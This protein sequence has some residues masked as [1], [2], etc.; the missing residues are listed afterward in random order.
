M[1]HVA[2]YC[3]FLLCTLYNIP[4]PNLLQNIDFG[5][6]INLSYIHVQF[7]HVHCTCTCT[8]KFVILSA[9]VHVLWLGDT[10]HVLYRCTICLH[11]HNDCFPQVQSKFVYIYTYTLYAHMHIVYI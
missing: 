6:I 8:V 5:I 7:L 4:L 10:L 9:K 1:Y 11:G 2:S 3:K